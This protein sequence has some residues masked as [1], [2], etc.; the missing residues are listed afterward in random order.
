MNFGHFIFCLMA[1][2]RFNFWS[3][4]FGVVNGYRNTLLNLNCVETEKVVLDIYSCTMHLFIPACFCHQM[5][6][7]PLT[8]FQV[9]R[10]VL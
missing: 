10:N 9:R 8:E 5:I 3:Y 7:V 2:W 6:V 4:K 1:I